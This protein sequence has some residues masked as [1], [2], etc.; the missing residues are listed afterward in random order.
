MTSK[1]IKPGTITVPVGVFVEIHE[2]I[3]ADFLSKKG[4]DISF[5]RPNRH[6]NVKS[7][8]LKMLGVSWEMKCPTGKSNRT[9]ENNIRLALLQSPN[10]ILDLRRIDSKIPTRKHL[11]YINFRFNT[12]KKIKRIAVITKELKLIDFSR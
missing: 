3:T 8:D 1:N 11:T 10:I 9:I 7:P 4:Y 6:K 2:K 5:I 12:T